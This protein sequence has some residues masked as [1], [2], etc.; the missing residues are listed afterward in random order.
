MENAIQP[1]SL[2]KPLLILTSAAVLLALMHLSASFLMP[3]LLAV[4]FAMLLTPLYRW[5][6]QKRV[7]GGLS[8]LLTLGVL[9]VVVVFLIVLVGNSMTTLAEDLSSYTDQFS[10]RQ[11]ELA[12]QVQSLDSTGSIQSLV[13][14]VKP[15]N[16][17]GILSSF[18][19]AIAGILS[20]SF[21]ILLV[22][23]FTL[24]EGSSL[25]RRLR[26]SFGADHYLPQNVTSLA[27]L[28]ISYFGLR[29][30]VNLVVAAATGLMFWLLGI[31]HAG[32]WAVLT[33]F[34]S[35]IPYI[36]A[37]VAGIPPVLLAFAQG[38]LGLAI[39]V[40]VLMI[41]INTICENIVAPMIM[42]KGLSISPIVVF[43]SFLFW[44][45][46]LGGSGALIAMPLT[47]GVILFMRSF[48]ETRNLVS[49]VIL[50]PEGDGKAARKALQS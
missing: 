19:S 26:Q 32:L 9:V 40:I 6:K 47:L 3:I 45:F 35:F 39:V 5:L 44:M 30:I 23:A 29:A 48:E 1:P 4:F 46:I 36:G 14:S 2:F 7:P 11:A 50:V 49:A 34:L 27:G 42:G 25:I 28:M 17:T 22:I 18:V 41:M 31:P 21:I 8:L 12:A 13:S 20:N 38:G 43:L 33:F 24:A 10:Q 37:F 16:L 15:S